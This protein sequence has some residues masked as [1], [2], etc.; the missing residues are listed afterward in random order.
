MTI[1]TSAFSDYTDSI[2][3]KESGVFFL[4]RRPNILFFFSD[5]Q[6]WDTL[7]CYGQPLDITPN[8]DKLSR[9]GV[10]FENAFTCQPVCGPARACLQTGR[11][12]TQLGCYRNNIALPQG[13]KT[14]ADYF[15]AEGYQTAYVGKWHLASNGGKSST[16]IGEPF[17]YSKSPVP[18][19]KRGGYEWWRAADVLEDTSHGFG[20]YVFDE[21]GKKYDF[22]KYRADAIT[23]Y[24]LEYLRGRDSERPFFLFLSQI[25]PHHQNNHGHYE[26]PEGSKQRF[27]DFVAP[28]DL[29]RVE[30]DWGA[31]WQEEYPDY[32]GC[33]NSLDENLG[34]LIE[35]LERQN[36]L[37]DTIIV[38]TSDHGSHFNTRCYEYKRSCHEGSIH[39]PLIIAGGPFSGGKV[40]DELISLLDLPP[41]L[42]N[43]ADCAA[44]NEM[45]GK[46][47]QPLLSGDTADWPSDVFIQI[48][49]S[50]V[51]RAIRTKKYKYSVKAP[52]KN[53][54]QDADSDVYYEEYLYDLEHDIYE[55]HNLVSAAEYE[56]QRQSLRELLKRRMGEAGEKVPEIRPCP[57]EEEEA[58]LSL[59]TKIATIL[60]TPEGKALLEP[61]ITPFSAHIKG[62]LLKNIS[63][64]DLFMMAGDLFPAEA[65]Q[66][67]ESALSQIKA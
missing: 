6:R 3:S 42:L 46:A 52:D 64:Q 12:A 40:I 62:N 54:W 47:I 57:V 8:L 66:A 25:E 30:N 31:D 2:I 7:G 56:G 11:V 4:Y 14:L 58:F 1:E 26:G 32:L 22:S 10:R 44:P 41:T 55:E 67:L 34:R 20:G 27:K 33:C 65:L 28:Q 63:L 51:G 9:R 38:Y 61:F 59:K 5:Q 24:A 21:N 37:D 16:D 35:E 50:Q 45:V 13:E 17:N 36:I 19:D 23:D 29:V 53:P 60:S 43:M 39:I 15:N 49:E 18:P 48:S